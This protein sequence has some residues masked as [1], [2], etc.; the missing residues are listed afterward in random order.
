[1]TVTSAISAILIGTVAGVVGRLL[2]PGKQPIGMFLAI[3]VGVDSAFVGTAIAWRS[4]S[5]PRL[6][7]STGS[8]C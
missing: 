8:N 5:L 2:F 6:A 3:L 4:V 7:A 1:M